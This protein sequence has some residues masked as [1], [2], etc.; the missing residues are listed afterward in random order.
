MEFA[1][2]KNDI[3]NSKIQVVELNRKGIVLE[4]EDTIFPIPRKKSITTTHPFFIGIEPLLPQITEKTHFP[5]VNLDI[6]SK[7]LIVDVDIIP[8]EDKVYLLIFDF[9][10]HYKD[11]HPL[12]QEKNEASIAKDKLA[13]ERQL[14]IAKEEFKNKFLS[15]LNHEIRNPLNS[16][17]GFMDVLRKTKLTYEQKEALNVMHETG[18]H[19]K[20]LMDDLLDISRIEKGITDIKNVPFSINKS[21]HSLTRHFSLK[22]IGEGIVLH[23]KIHKDVPVRVLGD[24]TR[25][26]QI[27]FNLLENAFRNTKEGTISVEALLKEK[28]GKKVYITFIVK[29][30]GSGISKDNLSKVFDSYMQLELNKIKPLGEG[31]GLRIVK[32]LTGLLGGSVTVDSILGEGS[33]FNITLPFEIRP[34]TNKKSKTVPK[35]TGIVLSKRILIVEDDEINQMLFMKT[36]INNEKAFYIE[37]AQSGEQAIDLLNKK[38]YDLVITKTKLPDMDCLDIIHHLR[39]NSDLN[40]RELPALVVSGRTMI[41]EQ[42]KVKESGATSF[43]SKPYSKKE[44]FKEISALLD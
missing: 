25:L 44:L 14:L 36:F 9:T 8:N 42:K 32:E 16:L 30:T 35:G 5:C 18:M 29:D 37:I 13:F 22:K 43:L 40:L 1:N 12:V 6:A 11:S 15:N 4:S 33:S 23:L 38:K 2:I 27:L 28:K 10:E 41:E 31:L 7:L 34:K 21:L 39:K 17:L 24:P 20:I 19:I 3:Y 26:N